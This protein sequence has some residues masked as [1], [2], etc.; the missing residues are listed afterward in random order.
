MTPIY[1]SPLDMFSLSLE[2]YQ[3]QEEKTKKE[4][5]E[6]FEEHVK[7]RGYLGLLRA[8][9]EDQANIKREEK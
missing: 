4:Q 2:S 8:Y 3:A 6:R 1:K 5:W 7:D 9:Q